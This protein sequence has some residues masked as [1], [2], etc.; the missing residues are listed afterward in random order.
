MEEKYLFITEELAESENLKHI[1]GD[2]IQEETYQINGFESKT[3]S[4]GRSYLIINKAKSVTGKIIKVN[5]QQIFTLD[6]WKQVPKLE[7]EF[8]EIQYKN[9]KIRLYYYTA[10]I[11][12]QNTAL[13]KD[14][15]EEVIKFANEFTHNGLKYMDAYFMIP[16][17]ISKYKVRSKLEYKETVADY[18]IEN[19]KY[20]NI[21]EFKS[22]FVKCLEREVLGQFNFKFEIQGKTFEEECYVMLTKH[23][24]TKLGIVTI[25]APSTLNP[26]QLLL[27][28]FVI[29]GLKI[30]V[31][32]K[33]LI[34]SEWLK[35]VG[36][37]ICGN[38]KS[39][40]FSQE[41]IDK[42]NAINLLACEYMPMGNIMGREFKEMLENNIAQYDTA[43]VYTS[44]R[45]LIEISN[46]FEENI[47]ARIETQA[48]EIFFM[49]LIMLQDAAIG[50]I[51]T[52][53]TK[54]LEQETSNPTRGNNMEVLDELACEMSQAILFLD[55][56]SFIFPTVKIS[57]KKIAKSFGIE[58]LMQKYEKYK[59]ILEKLINIHTAKAEEIENNTTNN[60][61]MVLT[62]TQVLPVLVEF[63]DFILY[64][65]ITVYKVITMFSS[66]MACFVLFVIFNILKHRTMKKK[67]RKKL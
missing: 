25:Y 51:C 57:A 55:F 60:I 44:E 33:T 46:K 13:I 14:I 56:D 9:E 17:D 65:E 34:L 39:V 50:R 43:K 8:I 53:V 38:L 59:G 22:D 15:N 37:S 2:P 49:E 36:I 31:N 62:I 61:L 21:S 19:V 18:L 10:K 5:D 58:D 4:N 40:I 12:Q 20:N 41:D 32:N 3:N 26:V 23:K 52:K 1:L 16:C 66:I 45:C 54:E 64:G 30:E 11:E 28:K 24:Q 27:A 7:R 67:F 29:D 6:R 35:S 47:Q 42:Q 63:F 48:I